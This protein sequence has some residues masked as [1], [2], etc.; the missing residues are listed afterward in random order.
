[1]PVMGIL[2]GES[3]LSYSGKLKKVAKRILVQTC[4]SF[5]CGYQNSPPSS[6]PNNNNNNTSV[7]LLVFLFFFWFST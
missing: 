4:N 2:A 6:V 1:M 3:S 7:S 5:F